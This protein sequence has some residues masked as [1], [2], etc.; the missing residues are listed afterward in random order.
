[1]ADRLVAGHAHVAGQ[2]PD[3][4]A[5]AQPLDGR[6]LSLGPAHWGT[7]QAPR[8]QPIDPRALRATLTFARSRSLTAAPPSASP[9]PASA[10][11][12][13]PA[14]RLALRPT[15]RPRVPPHSSPR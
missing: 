1:M 8:E 13:S 10:T 11:A 2:R 6:G 14:D 3:R 9:V 15:D 7:F 12:G 5:H 4:A